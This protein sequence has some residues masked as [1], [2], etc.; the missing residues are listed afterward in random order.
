MVSGVSNSQS[1][2]LFVVATPIGNREDLTPRARRVLSAVGLIAAEDTR[3]SRRLLSSAGIGAPLRAL[4][5]HNEAEVVQDL[6]G[7]L[8]AGTDVAL[9]SDA[10]TPLISDPG[11]LLVRACQDAGIPVVPVPGPSALVTALSVSGLPTNRFRF[12]GFLPRTSSRRRRVLERLRRESATLV[13]YEAPHRIVDAL[14]D[15]EATFGPSREAVLARELTK[16]HETVIRAP[17]GELRA[18]VAAD[19][20]QRLG[21]MVILVEGAP[22]SVADAAADGQLDDI[23]RTLLDYLPVKK[24]AAVAARLTGRKK[25]ALY[26]RALMI[27]GRR[28]G[29]SGPQCH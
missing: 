17:L 1:G 7:V 10:G 8:K 28:D 9:V 29:P 6:V 5:E 3:H 20:E 15:L 24:A 19:P 23:L 4:H 12:E 11:F 16:L 2:R 27:R 14:V 21:E 13:F 18:L 22:D 26:E 25:N